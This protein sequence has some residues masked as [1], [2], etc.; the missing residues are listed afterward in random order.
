M[1]YEIHIFVC[2][3]ERKNLNKRSCGESHGLLLIQKLKDAFAKYNIHGPFT[4][5]KADA[6]ASVI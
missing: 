6:L 1:I 3:N 5:K 2:T 4:Y